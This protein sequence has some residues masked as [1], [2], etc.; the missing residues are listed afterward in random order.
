MKQM[1]TDIMIESL[2]EALETMMFMMALPAAEEFPAPREL[3]L[4][5]I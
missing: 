2:N 5:H 1:T 4:I 3:S